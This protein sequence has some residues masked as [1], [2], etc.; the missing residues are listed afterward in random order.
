[1]RRAAANRI[2]IRG[3][4][5]DKTVVGYRNNSAFNRTRPAFTVTDAT[6][7]QLS[8]RRVETGHP[9]AGSGP[10]REVSLQP[11]R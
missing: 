6:D 11:F 9:R 10:R 3:E 1:M 4:D 2:P 5:R 7:I 8:T